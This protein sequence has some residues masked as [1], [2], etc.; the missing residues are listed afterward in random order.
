MI[1]VMFLISSIIYTIQFMSGCDVKIIDADNLTYKE[2]NK[3]YL[4]VS[5]IDKIKKENQKFILKTKQTVYIKDTAELKL[6]PGWK[7]LGDTG[8]EM[9]IKESDTTTS[10]IKIKNAANI[11][12]KNFQLKMDT[13]TPTH[14]KSLIEIDNENANGNIEIVNMKLSNHYCGIWAKRAKISE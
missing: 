1:K 11:Q 5:E 10:A 8:E 7:L 4:N 14:E 12:V 13:Y 3:L 2:S 6:K 9:V